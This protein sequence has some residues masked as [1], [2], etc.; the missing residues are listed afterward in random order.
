MSAHKMALKI[1]TRQTLLRLHFIVAMLFSSSSFAQISED[2]YLNISISIFE[3]NLPSDELRQKQLNIYSEVRNAEARYIPAL[4][5]A[6]LLESDRWGAIRIIPEADDNAELMISGTI[7]HSDGLKLEVNILVI[8][9]LGRQ[10]IN[11]NYSSN[12]D[13]STSLQQP[14]I[15]MDPFQK[16]YNQI[17]A[18]ISH[19]YEQLTNADITHIKRIAFLRYAASLAPASFNHYLHSSPEGLFDF[20]QFPASN[21]PQL[22]RVKEI[23][24]HEYLFIDIVDEQY[25]NFLISIKPVYDLW[26]EY[27]RELQFNSRDYEQSQSSDFQFRR[28][29]YR[30]LKESYNN[31]RWEK[32]QAQYLDELSHGFS[33]EVLATEMALDNSVYKLAG[34]LENQ[35]KEWQ[36]ILYAQFKLDNE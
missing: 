22:I 9:S 18:D 16:L 33:N 23:Q 30:A 24:Q 12:S 28:G 3:A 15:G 17:Q 13:D 36:E 6:T 14:E 4:L 31:Y 5:R 35:Y 34:T 8:D 20:T 29:T 19:F 2:D 32:M 26:R 25:Q 10:W 21:N 27:S 11:Q 7:I 1:F